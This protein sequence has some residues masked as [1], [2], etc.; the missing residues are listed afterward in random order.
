MTAQFSVFWTVHFD[1]LDPW[2]FFL[3]AVH[4]MISGPSTFADRPLSVVWTVQFN[5]LSEKSVLRLLNSY[6]IFLILYHI[7]LEKKYA[8]RYA[9]VRHYAGN[10]L[11]MMTK[12]RFFV[13]FLFICNGKK[14]NLMVEY[15]WVGL[16]WLGCNV[17]VGVILYVISC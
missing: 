3:R 10:D 6:M 14:L 9:K 16:L 12:I 7:E 13:F 1:L 4:V 15:P 8:R 11:K 5:P 17:K 2:V